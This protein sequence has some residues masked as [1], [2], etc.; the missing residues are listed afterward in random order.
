MFENVLIHV[1]VTT[2]KLYDTYLPVTVELHAKNI[3]LLTYFFTKLFEANFLFENVQYCFSHKPVI[4]CATADY[5]DKYHRYS[6]ERFF[7]E[8]SLIL[9]GYSF[10]FWRATSTDCNNTCNKANKRD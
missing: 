6:I 8:H 10:L 7:Y 3:N 2:V 1:P 9:F 4:R 5:P